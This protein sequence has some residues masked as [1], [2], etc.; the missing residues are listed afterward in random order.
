MAN[1]DSLSRLPLP[2][3]PPDSQIPSPEDVDLLLNHISEVIVTAS[4]I[5]AWTEKD[6]ILSRVHHLTLHGWPTSNSD[7]T[8]Q[9]YFNHKDELSVVD[10][11]VLWGS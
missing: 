9:P 5:K 6:P 8:L 3:Q 11:C 1:A 10:G 2:D 4:Q 7:A